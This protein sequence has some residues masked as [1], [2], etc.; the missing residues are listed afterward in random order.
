[1]DRLESMKA[2]VKV[3]DEGSFAG[4][5]RALDMSPSGVTKLIADLEGHLG[6]RLLNRT[7]RKLALT[8]AGRVYLE[9]LRFILQELEETEAITQLQNEDT[10][11]VLK[12]MTTPVLANHALTPFIAKFR[13]L[14]PNILLDIEV[15][16]VIT[17]HLDEFDLTLM[18]TDEGYNGNVAARKILSSENILVA[19]PHY[20]E[21]RGLP[22]AP[23]DLIMHCL[24]GLR[25]NGRNPRIWSLF[26]AEDEDTKKDLHIEPVMWSNNSDTLITAAIDH[27]GITSASIDLVRVELNAGRLIR[28][29]APWITGRTNLYVAY[30]SRKFIPKRT[31]L[32][33]E[34]LTQHIRTRITDE[35]M[36]TNPNFIAIPKVKNRNR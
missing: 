27:V 2:F 20:L 10:S 19:S 3:V 18:P 16:S 14:Y 34:F 31:K 8:T 9:R 28:I 11:G 25:V 7:T 12:I 30:P 24:L 13:T 4:A 22:L 15:R 5:S 29:L 26:N 33:V 17:D 32:F 6:T 35:K 21:S 1:M 23:E 36:T